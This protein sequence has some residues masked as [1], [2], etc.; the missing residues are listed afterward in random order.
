MLMVKVYVNAKRVSM[1]MELLN[2]KVSVYKKGIIKH[3]AVGTVPK[4]NRIII[5][6]YPYIQIHDRSTAWLGSGT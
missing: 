6:K 3:H 4:S 1:V 2:A 5:E